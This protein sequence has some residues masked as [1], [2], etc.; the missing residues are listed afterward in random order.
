MVDGHVVEV[1]LSVSRTVY[2]VHVL[3]ETKSC[4]VE[5]GRSPSVFFE[6]SSLQII[7]LV[8]GVHR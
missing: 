3:E 5:V 2:L 6:V 7:S 8:I 4:T 1:D